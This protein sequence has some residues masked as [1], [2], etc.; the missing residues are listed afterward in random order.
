MKTPLVSIIIPAHNAQAYLA[1]TLE[2]ALAQTWSNK[3]ILV[4]DDKSTDDT[5]RIAESFQKF[6]VRVLVTPP[7]RSGASAARNVGLANANGDNIQYLDADDLLSTDKIEKQ[8]NMLESLP[9][10]YI[11]AC[12]WGKF[13]VSPED[14]VMEDLP[15][16]TDADPIDWLIR[17]WQ[18]EGMM[19]TACWLMPRNLADKA[20]SWDETLTANPA[21]D[22]EYFCRVLL[23]SKGIRFCGEARVY[24]REPQEGNVSSNLS[25]EAVKSLFMNCERYSERVLQVEDSERVRHALMVN[26][27][28]FIYIFYPEFPALR[29]TARQRINELGYQRIPSDVVGGINFRKLAKFVGF[30]SA[31][32]LRRFVTSS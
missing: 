13:K 27:A 25:N 21:D 3:E 7:E 32:N 2:C 16:F 30:D 20:G 24:Y 15:I 5:R 9:N 8:V 22:G 4:V 17:A 12:P 31:L 29:R 11:A 10:N 1:E 6:Q 26:Y 14:A 28:R 18:G 23:Q 19:Q